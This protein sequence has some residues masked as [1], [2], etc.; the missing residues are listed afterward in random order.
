VR[1]GYHGARLF[2]E[3]RATYSIDASVSERVYDRR[4]CGI[5]DQ[6]NELIANVAS[7]LE[8]KRELAISAFTNRS[9]QMTGSPCSSATP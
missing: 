7:Q 4:D 6:L 3:L 1:T 2:A 5:L 9:A 8:Y